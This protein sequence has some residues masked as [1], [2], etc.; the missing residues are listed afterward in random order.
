LD[1]GISALAWHPSRALLGIGFENG[2]AMLLSL[3]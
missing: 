1:A 2:E 3:E